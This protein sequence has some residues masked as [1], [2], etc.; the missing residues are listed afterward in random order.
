MGSTAS[1]T[2]V[3]EGVKELKKGANPFLGDFSEVMLQETEQMAFLKVFCGSDEHEHRERIRKVKQRKNKVHPNILALL[4]M[5]EAIDSELCGKT[6]RLYCFYEL[7]DQ[8]LQCVYGE[9]LV[10]RQKFT[11]EELMDI[12]ISCVNGLIYIQDNE[13]KRCYLSK[14]SIVYVR[15]SVKIL[16]HC[17]VE[18]P[19]PYF[20]LHERTEVED[21][22]FLSPELMMEL[23]KGNADPYISPKSDIFTLGVLLIN[24]ALFEPMTCYFDYDRC[25]I[26]F[27]RLQEKVEKIP[28]SENLKNLI[29]MMLTG[30]EEER[31]GLLTVQEKLMGSRRNTF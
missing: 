28:Y 4:R 20:L 21:D 2:L 12:A 6:C 29:R 7:F 23:S 15:R 8:D 9:R 17:I 22:V 14:K 18:Q 13:L 19:H 3:L 30:G 11:E 10:N 26:D 1:N 31:P 5:D 16:D 25:I 24:L 27:Q